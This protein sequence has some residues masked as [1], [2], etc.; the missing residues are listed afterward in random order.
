M[1]RAIVFVVAIVG[2]TVATTVSLAAVGADPAYEQANA[3]L[4]HATPR[5]PRARVLVDERIHG[6]V[7]SVP[8]EAVQRIYFLSQP[9]TQQAVITFYRRRLGAAWRRRG[10]SCFASRSRLI[11]TVVSTKRRRLGVLIDSRGAARCYDLAGQIGDL[12]ELGYP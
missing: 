2:P 4:A 3:N 12:L 9:T 5:Y 8:F 10:A 6:E 1:L 7:G 11:I